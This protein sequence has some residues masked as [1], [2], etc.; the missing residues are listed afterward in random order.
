MVMNFIEQVD[1]RLL[2]REGIYKNGAIYKGNTDVMSD[3]SSA[4]FTK[5]GRDEV[6]GTDDLQQFLNGLHL[7]DLTARR[8]FIYDNVNIPV[9]LDYLAA[10]TLVM[11]NDDV[12]KNY[13]LYCDTNDGS[14]ADVRLRQSRRHQRMGHDPLGQGSDLRKGLRLYGLS[15]LGSLRAS[16]L[17]RFK[18]S[19]NRRSL[20]LAVRC[21][22]RHSRD[23]ADVLAAAA[24]ADGRIAATAGHGLCR[25]QFRESIRQDL[26]GDDRA[27]PWSSATWAI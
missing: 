5:I 22:A 4:Y 25:P 13:Y 11:D 18:S 24:H 3:S 23:Q 20:Q 14:N 26:R 2:E 6:S 7:T 15:N 27:I 16:V 10:N 17:R 21:A 19:E 12:A 1:N 9:M 8:N